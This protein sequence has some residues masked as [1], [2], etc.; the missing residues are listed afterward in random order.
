MQRATKSP[1]RRATTLGAA[2]LLALT[3]AAAPALAAEWTVSITNATNGT[4]FTPFVVAAHGDHTDVFQVGEPASLDVQRVAEC[5]DIGGV[6][7]S[8]TAAHADLDVNPAGGRL[9]PGMTTT[10][11]LNPAPWQDRLSV[12]AML[13][14]TND[15]FVGLDAIRVPKVPG[16]YTYAVNGY[17][18]GTE[19]N[20]EVLDTSGCAPGMPGIPGDPT[21]LAGTG[22][23]GVATADYNTYVHIHPGVVGDLD[24]DGGPSDLDPSVH[25]WNNPVGYV[26]VTVH[27]GHRRHH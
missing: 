22:G 24:P 16:T 14:P 13:I 5:G 3:A 23:T 7:D 8:L 21:G 4:Y 9:A 25:D 12:I 11:V 27:P 17:D 19:A 20:D 18:A 1:T 6:V 15:G 26:T 10:A 2:C